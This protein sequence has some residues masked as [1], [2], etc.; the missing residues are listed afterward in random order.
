MKT[1]KILALVL[2]AGLIVSTAYA[3]GDSKY[4]S[5]YALKH[6]LS[7]KWDVFFTPELRLKKDMSTLYYYQMRGGA[8]LH[9]HKHLDASLAYRFIQTK[10]SK[11]EWDNSDMH[12]VE[13]IV[14]PKTKLGGFNL[15]DANKIEYRMLENA[16]DRWVYRNLA[17][18]AY[19]AKI[20]DFEFTP[21]VSNEVYYD[22]EI[23]KIN[24][25]WTTLGVTKKISPNLS[26]GL[27]GRAETTRVGVK[28]EWD[29]N[30]IL[31]TNVGIEF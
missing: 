20:G 9:A 3:G 26:L 30:F 14:I 8:T 13:C 5:E 25:N 15:S 7:D 11:G 12:Y 22:F 6:K 23:E 31:G 28:D 24:L 17:S 18:I 10:D 16:R 1:A 2:A 29:T 4:Y 27:Y 19:P 21:Y